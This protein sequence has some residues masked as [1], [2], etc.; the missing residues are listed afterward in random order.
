M[1]AKRI[2]LLTGTVFVVSP[3]TLT[4]IICTPQNTKR[5]KRLFTYDTHFERKSA[6]QNTFNIMSGNDQDKCDCFRIVKS[7]TVS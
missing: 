4:H 2:D 7:F 5:F 1:A 6:R 3:D